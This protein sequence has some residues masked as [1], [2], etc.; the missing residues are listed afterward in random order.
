MQISV[1]KVGVT[2][3]RHKLADFKP[4][5]H[6][7]PPETL[8][9]VEPRDVRSAGLTN[10]DYGVHQRRRPRP[11]YPDLNGG[12]VVNQGKQDVRLD[13]ASSAGKDGP[14]KPGL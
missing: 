1:A 13:T 7:Y 14:P 5:I 8:Q 10:G 9:K 6:P 11:C 12:D 3:W 2:N 4:S